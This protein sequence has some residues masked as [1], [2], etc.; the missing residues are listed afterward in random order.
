MVQIFGQPQVH[1]PDDHR[2]KHWWS[3][4][5]AYLIGIFGL[6]SSGLVALARKKGGNRLAM[7]EVTPTK[8][9]AEFAPSKATR[10]KPIPMAKRPAESA[11]SKATR[12]KPTPVGKRP[13]IYSAALNTLWF[14]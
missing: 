12:H 13:A 1:E 3:E 14:L 5:L 7:G 11:P 6:L 9:P 10:H 2:K 8:P 4:F